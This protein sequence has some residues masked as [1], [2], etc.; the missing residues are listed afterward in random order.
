MKTPLIAEVMKNPSILSRIENPSFDICMAAHVLDGMCIKYID[1]SLF[2][3]REY[4]SMCEAAVRQNPRVLT[5]IKRERFS[6]LKWENLKL[7]VVMQN[8]LALRW[9]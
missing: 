1:P 6:S 4:H 8:G 2:T 3:R 5:K 7:F 9:L